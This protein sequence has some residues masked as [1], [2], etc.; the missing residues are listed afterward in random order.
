MSVKINH[1]ERRNEFSKMIL[2]HLNNIKRDDAAQISLSSC[3]DFYTFLNHLRVFYDNYNL[4]FRQD[5]VT[6]MHYYLKE[7]IEFLG[8]HQQERQ[9]LLKN[10]TFLHQNFKDLV[11]LANE[12]EEDI[13]FIATDSLMIYLNEFL[14][15][16]PIVKGDAYNQDLAEIRKNISKAFDDSEKSERIDI[17][18]KLE[19]E[20][21]KHVFDEPALFIQGIV[22]LAI[23]ETHGANKDT[24]VEII[25]KMNEKLPFTVINDFK[26][27]NSLGMFKRIEL[28]KD[29]V[30]QK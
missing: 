10:N 5:S 27:A 28:M 12:A 26:R 7:Y 15:E 3:Q 24:L 1:R 29:I 6:I 18:S 2:S 25:R 23:D 9:K 17:Y 30:V 8:I 21:V 11:V 22:K 4:E 19:A 16:H 13:R 20:M 14:P